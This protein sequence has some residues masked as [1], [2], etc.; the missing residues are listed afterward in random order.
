[1]RLRLLLLA[2]LLLY[3]S[4]ARAEDAPAAQTAESALTSLLVLEPFGKAAR[5]LW[6]VDPVEAARVK[7]TLAAPVEG[8]VV[9]AADGA[10]RAWRR[11]QA[12]EGGA[13]PQDAAWAG[14]Y[15]WTVVPSETEEVRLL[16]VSGPARL[17][18]NGE[19]R[20]GDVYGTIEARLPVLLRRGTNTLLLRF[21][22][23]A[24]RLR[25]LKPPAPLFFDAHDATLPD[26]LPDMLPAAAGEARGSRPCWIGVLL[27]NATGQQAAALEVETAVAGAPPLVQRVVPPPPY[28]LRKLPLQVTLPSTV[29]G[30]TVEVVVRVRGAAEA[31]R[32]SLDVKPADATH[33]RTFVSGLD[34]SVQYYAVVP[35][36]PGA[37]GRSEPPGI[38]LSLHGAS[39]EALGQA[40]AYAAKPDL[41]IVA[42]TNRRPYGF[43]WEGWGREDAREVLKDAQAHIVHH[44][45]RVCLTGHSMGGHGTWMIGAQS[46]GTFAAIAPSAGWRDVWSYGGAPAP[47]PQDPVA[48]LFDRAANVNRHDL[49]QENL[50]PTGVYVL[51]GDGDDNVPVSEAREM[52]ARLA[53]FH[54]NFAYFEQPGAGHWW[55]NECVDWPPL[56]AF[57]R[58]NRLPDPQQPREVRFATVDPRVL[59]GFGGVRVLAQ[60]RPR[61]VS[62]VAAQPASKDEPRV[63]VTTE[64]VRLLALHAPLVTAAG[65]R[66]RLDGQEL[67]AS[68]GTFA[69][70]ADGTW[71]AS[72]A[73]GVRSTGFQAAFAGR[74]VLVYG[75]RGTPEENAWSLAKARYD[76][77]TLW[78]RGNG[79][80]EVLPDTTVPAPE[81]AIAA[82]GAVL[83]GTPGTNGA[84]RTVGRPMP[85]QVGAGAI[86]VAER[87]LEGADLVALLLLPREVLGERSDVGAVCP[88]GPAGMR[89]ADTLP[90]FATG[91]AYPD[92]CVLSSDLPA[93]GAAG[94]RAA[95]YYDPEGRIGSDAAWR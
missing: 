72:A 7:G 95:G 40:R 4:A 41:V 45:R 25:W 47:T 78:Y 50:A 53:G 37:G 73:S 19:P 74:V 11:V 51:H 49:W 84:F 42:P 64:N 33:K 6:N 52:R 83:Y 90:F 77:E 17:F 34:G 48:A 85:C 43:D 56:F 29:P 88:T 80:P 89:L 75:T 12:G 13:Y 10:T 92:W 36:L 62:R 16:C 86:Q 81:G 31:L 57:L 70:G 26:V 30:P 23:G 15:G 38:V 39:V 82:G 44:P 76:A 71:T 68:G 93:L 54:R 1:M 35:A 14:G 9:T 91:V 2:C 21:G 65:A 58:E 22:R 46:P 69:R 32:L 87:R 24:P 28:G 18:W 61:E 67:E 66:L 3:P 59:E 94:A 60:Q 5:T 55:G 63:V 20:V 79:A 27:F 8:G